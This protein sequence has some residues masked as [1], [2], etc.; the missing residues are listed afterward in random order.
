MSENE[1][2][3]RTT[4]RRKM[5]RP[6]EILA[7]A[8]EEFVRTGYAGTRLEDVAARAGVT[9]GTIYFHFQSKENVFIQ[10]VRLFSQPIRLR[11]QDFLD[12]NA[13]EGVEFFNAYLDFS[14]AQVLEDRCSREILRLL[15][16]EASRFPSLTDEY[17]TCI[18]E[19]VFT[20]LHG[21][22]EKAISNCK[23][24]NA[25]AMDFPNLLLSP[26]LALNVFLLIFGDR[27]PIDPKR[28]LEAA[29]DLLMNGLLPRQCSSEAGMKPKK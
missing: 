15:I 23:I 16:A 5:E 27:K 10:M 28:Y 7:A 22:L 14:Y 12:D 3:R 4:S 1:V 17:F 29:K 8:F 6:N 25:E 24:R 19:P 11:T 9:K 2:G 13:A 20:R 21:E 18:F 26:M